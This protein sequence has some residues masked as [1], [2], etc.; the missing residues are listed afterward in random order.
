MQGLS[1]PNLPV[2]WCMGGDRRALRRFVCGWGQFA[3]HGC[4]I[5]KNWQEGHAT[6]DEG[7]ELEALCNDQRDPLTMITGIL[8]LRARLIKCTA[9]S[10]AELQTG[11]DGQM[12]SLTPTNICFRLSHENVA[13]FAGVAPSRVLRRTWRAQMCVSEPRE[14]PTAAGR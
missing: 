5:C 2:S 7:G 3:R 11:A 1:Y 14:N 13:G 10:E 4:R 12:P 9:A 6:S 8:C